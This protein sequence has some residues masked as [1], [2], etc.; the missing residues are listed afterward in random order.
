MPS[1]TSGTNVFHPAA[2]QPAARASSSD[3]SDS[4]DNDAQVKSFIMSQSCYIHIS[5]LGEPITHKRACEPATPISAPAKRVRHSAGAD[6]LLNMSVSFK[7]FGNKLAT[8]LA[9]PSTGVPPTPCCRH[10]SIVAAQQLE[11]AWLTTCELVAL[12]EFLRKDP[13][14]FDVYSA[15]TEP[16]VRKEWVRIQLE[17]IGIGAFEHSL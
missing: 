13:I 11:K 12:I 17:D 14:T 16:D 9:P 2:S 15:L 7:D 3:I 5:G 4:S 8:S 6:A 1:S 10:D